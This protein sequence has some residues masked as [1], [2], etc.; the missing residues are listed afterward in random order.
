MSQQVREG[1]Y[2]RLTLKPGQRGTKALLKEYG[3]R[4]M[5]VR[6]RHDREHHKRYKTVELIVDEADWVEEGALANALM[7]R[8]LAAREETG[9]REQVKAKG[10]R[11][12][13]ERQV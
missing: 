2:I 9:L 1:E 4:L 13:P 6:Y 11:W 7:I 5:C 3:H 8:E 12:N 10:G